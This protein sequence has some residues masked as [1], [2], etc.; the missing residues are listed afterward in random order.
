M[1]NK[2]YLN[3]DFLIGTCQNHI[4]YNNLPQTW[5]ASNSLSNQNLN[6]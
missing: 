5:G 1:S 6:W 4:L 3:N 2:M